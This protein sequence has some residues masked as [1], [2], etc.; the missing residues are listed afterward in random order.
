M[1]GT[2]KDGW[3]VRKDALVDI[4]ELER[5]KKKIS[6]ELE[7][8]FGVKLTLERNP[9]ERVLFGGHSISLR[10]FIVLVKLVPL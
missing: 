9:R 3:G 7:L 1:L 10:I 6:H 4:E 5:E 2:S 8:L